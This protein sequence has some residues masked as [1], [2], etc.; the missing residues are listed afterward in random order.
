LILITDLLRQVTWDTTPDF[1]G[2]TTDGQRKRFQSKKGSYIVNQLVNTRAAK[3]MILF[4][5]FALT[6]EG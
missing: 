1:H 5:R 3:G 4:R 2:G 6:L